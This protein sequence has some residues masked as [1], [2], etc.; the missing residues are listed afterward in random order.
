[1]ETNRI[2]GADS[3]RTLA[4]AGLVA[5]AV[6]AGAPRAQAAEPA[7]P[8]SQTFLVSG[9]ELTGIATTA[10]G[11]GSVRTVVQAGVLGLLRHVE[12]HE[13]VPAHAL[14]AMS[15]TVNEDELLGAEVR[16]TQF[17]PHAFTVTVQIDPCWF[18]YVN[19]REA[20]AD[21]FGADVVARIVAQG[22]PGALQ[23][24]V[25]A[26]LAQRL[27]LLGAKTAEPYVKHG[28]ILVP[29]R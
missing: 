29:P 7:E 11:D 10:A 6:L 19:D 27:A 13:T 24:T 16:Y 4:L 26:W 20:T 12:E 9:Q 8:I 14:L 15:I 1:M 22:P 17:G 25:K 5:A 18:E 3:G 28:I 21:E 2:Q 23:P